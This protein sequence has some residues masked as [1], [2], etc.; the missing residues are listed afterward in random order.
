MIRTG[1]VSVT[2]RDLHPGRIVDLV[3][4]ARLDAIEWGGD[5]H[6]PHGE[7]A[8]ARE[9]GR[10][11][12][13]AGLATAVYGSYYRAG[14]PDPGPG[15]AAVLETA[16]ALGAPTIRVWAGALGSDRANARDRAAVVDDT[17]R[18]AEMAHRE[19]ISLTFEFHGGTLND[20]NA[21][22]RRLIEEINDDRVYSCWQPPAG[23]PTE[24]CLEGL[25]GVLPRLSNLHVFTWSAGSDGRIVRHP[26]AEGEA[27]WRQYLDLA[28]SSG[29]DHYALIEFVKDGQ[30]G[31]F[32]QDARALKTWI[33]A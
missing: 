30:P 29:R 28:R 10:M 11:T 8:R 9:I 3:R 1:L 6:V 12:C 15:F 17:L 14:A 20:T 2:F 31:Q 18:I 33:G 25:R 5:I 32:L 13:E 27:R 7:V 4:Q 24:G 23:M 16:A 21:S 26:L 22:S 19:G